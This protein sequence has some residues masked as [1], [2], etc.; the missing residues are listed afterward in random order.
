MAADLS[1][2]EATV[3]ALDI[4]EMSLEQLRLLPPGGLAVENDEAAS[5]AFETAWTE[6]GRNPVIGSGTIRLLDGRLVRIQYFIVPQTDG[7]YEIVLDRA[8]EPLDAPVRMYAVGEA[9]AAWRAAERTL[10]ELEP[11]SEGWEDA[12]ATI[13][14]FRDDYRRLVTSK[15]GPT[16]AIERSM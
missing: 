3:P 14:R 9:L 12:Q 15:G 6:A 11:G 1:I 13:S 2:V 16:L 4:L 8:D 10:E 5:R 7:G